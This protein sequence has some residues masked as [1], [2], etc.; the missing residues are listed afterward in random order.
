MKRPSQGRL[1]AYRTAVHACAR[2]PVRAPASAVQWAVLAVLGTLGS[3]GWA[4]QTAG[5]AAASQSATAAE[6]AAAA[7]DAAAAAR[8]L[9]ELRNTTLA[10][11]DALVEQGLLSRAK[12]DELIR[13][14]QA[15]ASAAPVGAAV[16]AAAPPKP[17]WG[18]PR[19]VVRVPYLPETLKAE[20]REDIKRDVLVTARDEGWTDGRRLPGWVRDVTV[21]GDVR[22]RLQN[23]RFDASN[24]APELYRSQTDSPAWSPDLVNTQNDRTRLTLRARLGV[25]AKAG[26]D[27]SAAIRV[28]TGTTPASATQSLGND[29]NRYSFALDRAWVRWE[30]R[31]GTVLQGGRLA[32]P[33][34]GTDL[35]WPD[36]LSVDG[37][38]AH[39]ELD[40]ANGLYGF[41]TVGAFALQE[42]ATSAQDQWLYG[43]Q[44]G[45]DWSLT[46]RLQMRAALGVYDFR[47]I[48]GVREDNLPPTGP[49]AG[50]T[51]YQLSQYPASVRQKGNTLINL[52]AP[53]STAAPVWGLASKFRPV[54]LTLGLAARY[55]DPYELG[56]SLDFVRNS[57]FDLTD[58]TRR[59]GTTTVADLVNMTRGYQ[60]R[61]TFGK[62]ALLERGD[63]QGFIAYRKFERDAWVDAFTDTTWNLGGTNYKGFSLGGSY[64]VDRHATLGLRFTSTRNLDDGVRFLA[65]PGDPAS[66]SGDLSSA[67]LKID[68]LQIETNVRF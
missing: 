18:E 11:I 58:I 37:V 8:G 65:V 15:A 63:W 34:D 20:I 56:L 50:V 22:V 64:A 5:T 32:V 33:F 4:Q 19:T 42:F 12:A 10:L 17:T 46:G 66:I 38:S 6:S 24:T 52:N 44:G 21:Q 62:P 36:D 7:G 43:A 1:P 59:A 41:A 25:Q 35:L 45:F 29:F 40:I 16:A 53:G 60:A 48:E 30:P 31:Q 57:A 27:F 51:P 54:N 47:N 3:A 49:L 68:L 26:E 61:M 9:A 2:V 67:P 39:S 23:D 28:A 14:A 55:F 13:K